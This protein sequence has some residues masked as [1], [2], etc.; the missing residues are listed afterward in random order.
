MTMPSKSKLVQPR[1]S[2]LLRL[3]A[4][5]IQRRQRHMM[6]AREIGNYSSIHSS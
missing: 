4:Y 1:R 5:L 3:P 2:E 6:F